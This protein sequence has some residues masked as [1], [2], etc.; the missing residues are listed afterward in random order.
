MS[1]K[2]ANELLCEKE[3]GIVLQTKNVTETPDYEKE[4][5]AIIRSNMSPKLMKEKIEDYHEN[6]IASA[7]EDINTV[8]R[9]RL[10]RI[11]APA[12][13]SDVFEYIDDE[14]DVVRYL[15]ELDLKKRVETISRMEPDKLV[16]ILQKLDKTERGDLVEL[17]DEEVRREIALISSFDE[18]EIGSQMVTNYVTI[19][20]DM[21]VKQA[22]KALI[23]QAAE[24]DNIT[25]LY[26]LDKDGIYDG[27]VDLKDL[28]V[29][30]EGTELASLIQTSYPYV[31]AQESIDD[32]I[33]KIKDYSEDSIP[34]LDNNNRILGV[35]TSQDIIQLVDDEMG[36]DYAMLAGLTAEEDLEEPLLDSVKKRMPWLIILLGLGLVVSSVVGIFEG[37]VAQLTLVICFQSLILDMSGNVGTQSL[38]VT[39]RVLMDENLTGR[40]KIRLIGK[41]MRV[42]FSNGLLLGILSFLCIGAYIY[43]FKGKTVLLAFAISGC[44]GLALLLAMV[45][46]SFTGTVIPIFFKKIDVDPAVASGPL[47]TTINDLVA[48]V[49]YYGLTWIFLIQMLHISE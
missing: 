20:E 32:C 17:M 9:K 2:Q 38:A 39:I 37:V 47:I 48:V 46:S 45:I 23:D 25:T 13:L 21:T 7:L 30:R 26:V 15:N 41:E 43:F 36:E 44:I 35:L 3:D 49:T 34:I 10:Y 29:A 42:G 5:V 33:E 4:I 1:R 19:C 8:E 22:M 24:N 40:Q 6:D 18:D 27:A 11:L 12:D 31:Y 28:I 14:D 16:E